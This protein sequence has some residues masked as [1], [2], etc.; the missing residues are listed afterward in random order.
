MALQ[1]IETFVPQRAVRLQPRV[2]FLQWLYPNPVE[3]P[4]RVGSHFDESGLLHDAQVLRD[5]GLREL[6]PIDELAD[7][8]F[9]VA[10]DVED[11]SAV[12]FGEDL[13]RGSCGHAAEYT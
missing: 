13:D 6:E 2:E 3:A 12:G 9:A 11:S 4:L 1:P 5:R 10:Q 7:R 8:L